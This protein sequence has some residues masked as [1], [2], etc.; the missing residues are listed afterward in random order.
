MNNQLQNLLEEQLR[1][2]GIWHLSKEISSLLRYQMGRL[3]RRKVSETETRY[4]VSTASMRAF[5]EVFFTRH[6]FQVQNSLLNYMTSQDF[7]NIIESGR[8]SVLD[9]GSGPAVASLAITD[10]LVGILEC[11]R[12]LNY[13]PASKMVKVN[14]IL[15]D[16]VGICLDT[17]QCM[18][19]DYFRID[20]KRTEPQREDL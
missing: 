19:R 6:F 16:T 20:T 18:L 13:W 2:D 1:P 9:V 17:G 8:L 4:P 5:L 12:V 11:L 15:N 14:Y 10:M 3:P 7:L